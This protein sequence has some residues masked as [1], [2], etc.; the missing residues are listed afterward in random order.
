MIK[1][2][3]KGISNITYNHLNL[4]TQ[5]EFEGTNDKITYLYNSVGQKLKKTVV[6]SDSIKIVDYLDGFQTEARGS[7]I[8]VGAL[9]TQ[10]SNNEQ[11]AGNILQFFPH[12]EGYVKATPID[13][14]NTNYAFNYVFNYTDHLGNVRLSYSKD[15]RT[16]QLK[17]LEENHYYPFGLKHSVYAAG[18]LRDFEVDSSNPEAEHVF[19]TPVTK[20]DYQYKFGAK[21][22][23]DE[24]G[25]GWY[26]YH[27]RNYD[28]ALGRWNVIDPMAPKYF[29]HSPYAYTLNNPVYFIDPTGMMAEI[30]NLLGN[31]DPEEICE[32][33]LV[34]LEEA[35]ITAKDTQKGSSFGSRSR[36]GSLMTMSG[37]SSSRFSIG[38][39]IFGYNYEKYSDLYNDPDWFAG[40][41][42][43]YQA[44]REGEWFA[45]GVLGG[46]I[47]AIFAA[48]AVITYGS[49]YAETQVGSYIMQSTGKFALDMSAKA[50]FSGGDITTSDVTSALAGA[51]VPGKAWFASGAVAETTGLGTKTAMGEDITT[52]DYWSAGI[53]SFMVSPMGTAS[54]NAMEAVTNKTA[55]AVV[56]AVHNNAQGAIIDNSLKH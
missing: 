56:E 6:Y 45:V 21:E 39:N 19:L 49:I 48:P 1:D 35:L 12:A 4:P 8:P 29:S 41:K 22:W 9:A 37:F 44:K 38:R 42:K 34:E 20:T 14:L 32:G 25:L 23:Q 53:K 26:D 33:C 15:P 31:G 51:L 52:N 13:R 54:G 3:N 7:R 50:L 43:M 5:I 28:P 46:S 30:G 17:I 11:Y 2:R 27:A 47:V 40:Y 55:G 16:N 36:S 10:L 24:L 18:R